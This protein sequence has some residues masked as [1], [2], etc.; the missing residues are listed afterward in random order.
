MFTS[1]RLASLRNRKKGLKKL[2]RS[3]A[4]RSTDEQSSTSLR[5]KRAS[6][7]SMRPKSASFVSTGH[8]ASTGNVASKTSFFSSFTPRW[9][10]S[11]SFQ[12]NSVSGAT[13]KKIKVCSQI[14]IITLKS[15]QVGFHYGR[16]SVG[17]SNP[18]LFPRD[19]LSKSFINCCF[20][21]CNGIEIETETS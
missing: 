5:S 14:L 3:K 6:H 12:N 4:S 15:K 8:S 9:G 16:P 2:V 18:S 19:P 10:R 1:I 11:Q 7:E 17:P 13:E 21:L 20:P